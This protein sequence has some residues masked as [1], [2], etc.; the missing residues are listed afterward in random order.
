VIRGGELASKRIEDVC[1]IS[2][3][4]KQKVWDARSH[5]QSST[6]NRTPWSTVTNRTECAKGSFHS[7]F[8]VGRSNVM[9]W[10]NRLE[11]SYPRWLPG[12][13]SSLEG[14]E[15][16]LRIDGDRTDLASR[17]TEESGCPKSQSGL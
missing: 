5:P 3:S 4:R 14:A 13:Q 9:G 16:R 10:G 17:T 6:S 1:G 15:L 2:I 7:V 8:L 12:V 11:S